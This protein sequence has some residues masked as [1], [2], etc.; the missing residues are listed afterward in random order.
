MKVYKYVV[1]VLDFNNA[2]EEFA[3]HAENHGGRVMS[4]ESREIG[5]WDDNHP[6][7]RLDSERKEFERLF[8]ES[9]YVREE[10]QPL[11]VLGYSGVPLEAEEVGFMEFE[12][13][14]GSGT[15][16][17]YS[18]DIDYTQSVHHKH[19][20]QQLNRIYEYL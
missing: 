10:T 18:P 15:I 13:F 2:G 12:P 19:L 7:N 8:N 4:V 9:G 20:T 1:S 17:A 3:Y 14:Y 16:L 5:E 6:L 11:G